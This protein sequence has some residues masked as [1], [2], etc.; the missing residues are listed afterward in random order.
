MRIEGKLLAAKHDCRCYLNL[1]E[2]DT[3]YSEEQGCTCHETLPLFYP[4]LPQ[5][6]SFVL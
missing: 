3:L 6:P 2:A 1:S 5:H 4:H